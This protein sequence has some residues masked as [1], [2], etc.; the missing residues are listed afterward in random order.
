MVLVRCTQAQAR[1]TQIRALYLRRDLAQL[2]VL[3][4]SHDVDHFF[5][6]LAEWIERTILLQVGLQRFFIRMRLELMN[7]LLDSF[8]ANVIVLLDSRVVQSLDS[9]VYFTATTFVVRSTVTMVEGRCRVR[10]GVLACIMQVRR[11]YN[12][13]R[14]NKRLIRFAAQF[15]S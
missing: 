12:S 8:L 14:Y 2:E 5:R 3:H 10:A 9:E 4:V 1:A 13:L 15:F 6:L 7:Q 11:Q